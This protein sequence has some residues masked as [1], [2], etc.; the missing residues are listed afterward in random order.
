MCFPLVH[1]ACEHGDIADAQLHDGLAEGGLGAN[2]THKAVVA[3]CNAGIVQESEIE[4][5]QWAGVAAGGDALVDGFVLGR[6]V[7]GGVGGVWN[8]HFGGIGCGDLSVGVG[9]V[10][11]RQWISRIVSR[12]DAWVIWMG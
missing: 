9:D 10:W 4:R 12:E 2:G 3:I 5:N 6:G 11:R 1:S 7:G 8:A